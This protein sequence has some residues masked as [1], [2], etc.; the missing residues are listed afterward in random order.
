MNI[1]DNIDNI[2]N[3]DDINDDTTSQ[4]DKLEE[5]DNKSNISDENNKNEKSYQSITLAF[6]KQRANDRKEWLRKYDPNLIIENS[7]KNISYDEFINKDLI[8]FSNSDNIRSIP[9]ISD[10]LKIG[11]SAPY[12]FAIFAYFSES[13]VTTILICLFL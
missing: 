3:I 9:D 1:I 5:F 10:G 6:A 4:I 11:I 7:N 8:H 2:D 13:V 12:S